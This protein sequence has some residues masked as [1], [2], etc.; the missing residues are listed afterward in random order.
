MIKLGKVLLLGDEFLELVA[1]AAGVDAYVFDGNCKKLYEWLSLNMRIY[2]AIICLDTV[3]QACVEVE[4]LL[5]RAMPEKMIL[6]I[7]HPVK[8]VPEDPREYYKELARRVLGVEI[9]LS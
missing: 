9:V 1:L 7:K 8:G 5:K 4:D 3:T 2:D 6:R